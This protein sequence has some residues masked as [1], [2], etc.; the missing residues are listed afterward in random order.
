[1]ATGCT[2]PCKG[3]PMVEAACRRMATA[4]IVAEAKNIEAPDAEEND[5][6]PESDSG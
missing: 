2:R 5:R 3:G 1:M 6:S 4:T